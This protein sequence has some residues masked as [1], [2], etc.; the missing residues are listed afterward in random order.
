MYMDEIKIPEAAALIIERLNNAGK[1]AYI[2]GGCVRDCLLGKAPKDWDITTSALPAEV[3]ALFE[4]TYDT[5]IKHG[6]VTVL[7]KGESCEVT[8][9]RIDGEYTDKRHPDSVIFTDKLE[10]DLARRDFTMNAVAYSP[11]TGFV[12]R[13]GGM[14]DIKSG[15]IRAVG[16]PAER[17]NEDALRMM[18]A[19]RF[20]AQ[21]GFEIEGK[22]LDA[23]AQNS[24]LIKNVSPERIRDELFKLL[25]SP[26]PLKIYSLKQT[27]ILDCV[28]PL[29]SALLEER[30]EEIKRCIGL[31]PPV[32][33]KRLALLLYSRDKKSIEGF[34][35]ALR[36]DN[37]TIK[38]IAILSGYMKMKNDFSPYGIRKII[39]DTSPAMAADIID[40][41]GI[42][43]DEDTSAY[44]NILKAVI[45][46][47]ECCSMA[48]L[49]ING[50][51]LKALGVADGRQLGE[52]LKKCLDEVLKD[53]G[54]N[55]REYLIKEVCN[56]CTH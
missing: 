29:L 10:G 54:K 51:D 43:N 21:L 14:G 15:I 2:V 45:D 47:G 36:A 9:Y 52:M 33:A 46:N 49:A 23:I 41:Q 5:G 39:C 12:D 24:A 38:D 40:M 34:L 1:E 8:T 31:V 48:E 6:T 7:I 53:P 30:H 32:I 44:K 19:L 16:E 18:R 56:I 35:R 3:K 42:L 20:S 22:T 25:L 37:K 26:D 50:T 55:N 27:G 17:F 13:F 4:H 28:L 11:K